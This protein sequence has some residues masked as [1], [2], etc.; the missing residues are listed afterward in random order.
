[1]RPNSS[2]TDVANDVENAQAMSYLLQGSHI[3]WQIN[4]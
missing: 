1:M 2:S 4:P 3:H